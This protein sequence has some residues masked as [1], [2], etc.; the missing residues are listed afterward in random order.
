MLIEMNEW[1][2]KLADL[3]IH[4]PEVHIF[5]GAVWLLVFIW[6]VLRR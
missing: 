3:L 2:F 1:T 5:A 4:S 6:I